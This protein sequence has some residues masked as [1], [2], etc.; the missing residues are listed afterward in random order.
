M[1]ALSAGESLF[2][3]LLHNATHLLNFKD[4]SQHYE[5]LQRDESANP[6]ESSNIELLKVI[7]T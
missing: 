2:D 4:M 6:D 5:M 1:A 3:I 7:Q